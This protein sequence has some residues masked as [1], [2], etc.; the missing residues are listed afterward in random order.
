MRGNLWGWREYKLVVFKRG[1][2]VIRA[3]LGVG[4][5]L[6]KRVLICLG[7]A[8]A[9]GII[10]GITI[11]AHPKITVAMISNNV[12]DENML[13]AVKPTSTF[14]S[15]VLGRLIMIAIFCAITFAVCLHRWTYWICFVL[16]AYQGFTLVVNLYWILAK[17]GLVVGLPLFIVYLVLLLALVGLY[18][19]AIVYCM[20]TGAKARELGLKSGINLKRVGRDAL[21]ALAA[22]GVFALVEWLFY[23][24]ILSKIVF[25]V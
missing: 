21:V 15:L 8:L 12:L 17:F 10:V 3:N 11:A 20:R 22:A 1:I 18:I 5:R 4:W 13:R 19:C 6:N 23:F 16:A 2:Y 9:I 24:I 25:V 7:V 14:G